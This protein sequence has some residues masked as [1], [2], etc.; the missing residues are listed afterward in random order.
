MFQEATG[1]RWTYDDR[2]VSIAAAVLNAGYTEDTFTKD[3]AATAAWFIEQGKKP[4]VSLAWFMQK[5]ENKAGKKPQEPDINAI[6]GK[7]AK[8]V[9][10]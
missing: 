1:I 6:L 4:P 7:T 5:A 2:Q 9:R 8:A 3:A 10:W